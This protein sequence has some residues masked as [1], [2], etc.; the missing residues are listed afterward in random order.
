MPECCS[1]EIADTPDPSEP[2]VAL[3]T[4][5]YPLP[6]SDADEPCQWKEDPGACALELM[7]VDLF[8]AVPVQLA[9]PSASDLLSCPAIAA[10]LRMLGLHICG[11][12]NNACSCE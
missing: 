4:A 12:A 11:A 5:L 10:A 1:K 3:P 9:F 2:R 6:D 7:E 8:A